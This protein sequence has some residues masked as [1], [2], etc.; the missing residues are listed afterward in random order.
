ML[1]NPIYI[2]GYGFSSKV[3]S[4]FRGTKIDLPFHGISAIRYKDFYSLTEEFLGYMPLKH[5]I[6]GWSMGGSLA[7][8]LA[9]RFPSKVNRIFLIGVTPCFRRAWEP[10]NIRAFISMLKRDPVRGL[11]KFRKM[12][13]GEFNDNVDIKAS[14]AMLEDYINFDLL[15]FL[16]LIE[17]PVFIIHGTEDRIVPPREAFVLANLLT[18]SKLRIIPGGHF[19][20]RYEKDL[21]H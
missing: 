4:N 17:K 5:D 1:K 20:I 19:P 18:Y 11:S 14:F 10:K 3:F 13:Y 7:L 6:I 8:M 15:P 16:P 9:Y 2:H 21:I 12:A